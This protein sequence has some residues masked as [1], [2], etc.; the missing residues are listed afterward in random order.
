VHDQPGGHLLGLG[1]RRIGLLLGERGWQT[2]T[3][4]LAGYRSALVA[5]GVP[6]DRELVPRSSFSRDEAARVTGELLDRRPDVTAIFATSNVLAEG[7]VGEIQRR[8]RRILTD[9]SIVAFDDVP[10]MRL[11]QPGITTVAQPTEELGRTAA[12]L[13][14]D[15]V[16]GGGASNRP[17]VHRLATTLVLRGSTAA[18]GR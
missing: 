7:A 8:G 5:A 3:E 6:F 16:A 17:V 11:M 10:W 13:L 14:L 15:R 4:R 2:A 9:L 1:H 12:E 18:P